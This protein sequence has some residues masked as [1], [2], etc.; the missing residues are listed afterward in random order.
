MFFKTVV[1]D[2]V[3]AAVVTILEE[4]FP[5]GIRPNSVIDV[6]KMKNYYNEATDE[7]I[8]S[9]FTRQ[10]MLSSLRLRTTRIRLRSG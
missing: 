5:N 2:K 8:S 3:R 9:Y 7:E 6:N 10:N 1:D 4:R